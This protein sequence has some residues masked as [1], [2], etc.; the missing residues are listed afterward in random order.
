M[1]GQ[2]ETRD[3]TGT[4]WKNDRKTTD[5]HPNAK[6]DALIDGKWYWVSAWTKRKQDGTP[7]QSLSFTP[8]D[9]TPKQGAKDETPVKTPEF[10]DD[11]PF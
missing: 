3:L 6:G 7:F 10:D 4:L 1:A 8:K 11:I 2:F 9:D 5:N